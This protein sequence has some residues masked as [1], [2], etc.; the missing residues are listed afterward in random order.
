MKH[1]IFA[2]CFLLALGLT[3]C[4]NPASPIQ[5]P[6][7][8]ELS[9]TD[10]ARIIHFINA[11][12]G[13]IVENTNTI[14]RTNNGGQNWSQIPFQ[15]SESIYDFSFLNDNVGWVSTG[16]SLYK[17]TDAGN[18]WKII[19]TDTTHYAFIAL[20]LI[21]DKEGWVSGTKDAK[22]YHTFDGGNSW[23]LVN[24]N[25]IGKICQINFQNNCNGWA[26]EAAGRI[27]KTEDFGKNWRCYSNIRFTSCIYPLTNKICYAGNNILPSSNSSQKAS[28]YVT[29]D[30]G[31]NW[32]ELLFSQFSTINKIVF[33]D[34]NKGCAITDCGNF[35]TNPNY[36]VVGSKNILYTNNGG[37]SWQN[38]DI[39]DNYVKDV[40]TAG[41]KILLL[42]WDNR[43]MLLK[44]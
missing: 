41:N 11:S 43:L 26:M 12:T 6:E 30:G 5:N 31:S 24:L 2:V 28:I 3:K 15:S 9:K 35:E 16:H 21:N 8:V 22:L 34:E 36:R 17:T 23:E 42:L 19:L 4:G 32:R 25:A 29:K 10:G 33:T 37:K 13:W 44:D 7:M 18:S 27:Y 39:D 1:F 14:K 20:C 40:S 38:I